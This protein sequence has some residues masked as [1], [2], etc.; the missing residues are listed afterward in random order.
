MNKVS[1]RNANLIHELI[2]YGLRPYF[3]IEV[4]AKM[5]SEEAIEAVKGACVHVAIFCKEYA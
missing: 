4:K 1:V 2:T 5:P 3:G